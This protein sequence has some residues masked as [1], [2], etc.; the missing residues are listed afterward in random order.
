MRPVSEF[1]ASTEFKIDPFPAML[2]K[3]HKAVQVY[4]RHLMELGVFVNYKEP[5]CRT[6]YEDRHEN[7]DVGDLH[8]WLPPPH[9]A[10]GPITIHEL[11]HRPT[12]C[13]AAVDEYPYDT[14]IL[15]RT[16]RLDKKH[17]W[18]D[19]YVIMSGDYRYALR[20]GLEGRA[21]TVK[22]MRG[23][24]YYTCPTGWFQLV[25]LRI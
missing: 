22:K 23:L 18:P 14:V 9:P 4:G 16:Y 6:K 20:L 21:L 12:I 3:S 5:K 15:D 17:P 13:F 25:D 8:A 11:K 24:E 1:D 19:Y 2:A 7:V 10:T